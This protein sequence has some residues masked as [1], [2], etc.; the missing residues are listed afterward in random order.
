MVCSAFD[1]PVI[2]LYVM[3]NDNGFNF[4]YLARSHFQPL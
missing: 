2:I 3:E 4:P 1:G